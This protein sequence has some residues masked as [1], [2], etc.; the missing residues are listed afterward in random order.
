VKKVIALCG[1]PN[2]GKT[3][4]FN[5]LTGETRKTGN[6]SGVTVD[7]GRGLLA[8]R[9]AG[10]ALVEVIDLP[11]APSLYPHSPEESAALS[12]LKERKADAVILVIDSC[13]PAQGLYLALQLTALRLPLIL[14]FNM[15]D[16]LRERGGAIRFKELSQAL[17]VPCIPISARRGENVSRLIREALDSSPSKEILLFDENASPAKRFS[18]SRQRYEKIDMLLER[19]FSYPPQKRSSRLDR[20]ALHPL[21][22]Y[23]LLICILVAVFFIV[24][25]FPGQTL[26]S[27]ISASF[28][29]A[30]SGVSIFLTTAQTPKLLFSL[31]IEGLLRSVANVLSFLPLLLLFFFVT[32]LIE[33]SGYLSRAAFLLDAPLSRIGLSGRSFFPLMTGFGCSVPA[34]LSTRTLADQRERRRALQ[35]IPLIPCSAKQPVCL[36][37]AALCFS[38]KPALFLTLCYALCLLFFLICALLLLSPGKAS[39]PALVSDMPIWRIPTLR[40]AWNA[41]KNK[42]QDY[43]SRAFTVIFFTSLTVWFLRAFTPSLT[44][45]ARMNESLLYTLSN[46]LKPVLSPLGFPSPYA[47]AALIAGLLAKE[48]ILAVLL[49]SPQNEILFSSPAAAL[50]FLVFSLLYAP[51]LAA[52]AAIAQENKSRKRMLSAVL[53]QTVFAWLAARLIFIV[54]SR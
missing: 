8:E 1:C 4:L 17:R 28:D 33:D 14:A 11:G 13:A 39:P 16:L 20:I 48:N 43:I 29:K 3:T 34:L 42:T 44:L 12:F 46:L 9:Y 19:C 38:G 25:G 54:F 53:L 52:C 6:W 24:F 47:A 21:F 35:L 10:G 23:P 31:L 36:F 7:I 37:M 49:L 15:S 45:A 27:F 41:M 18:L 22:A 5:L 32:A 26:F 51:C 40:G 50:S 30:L 2:C